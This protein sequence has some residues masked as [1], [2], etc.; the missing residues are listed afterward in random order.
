MLEEAIGRVR[1][2]FGEE[3]LY[4]STSATLLEQIVAS[5]VLPPHRIWAEPTRRNTLGAQ[6][7]IAA[8]LLAAGLKEVTLA[9]LTSDHVIG[10]PD[11][12]LECINAALEIA[13]ATGG[14]VTIGVSPTRP[15]TGFGYIEEKRGTQVSAAGGATAVRAKSFREKP[16]EETAENFIA[17][18]NFLWNSG[19]FFFTLEAF[20]GE[21]QKAQP[22]A[23]HITHAIADLLR[24]GDL[25]EA[26]VRFEELPNISIDYAVMEKAD[27][28]YVLRATFPWDDIGS[29]DAMDRTRARDPM[30]N[31]L[32]GRV[33][34]ADSRD[35]IVMDFHPALRVGVLGLQDMVVIVGE[36]AVLVC[37][38]RDA[39][40]VRLIAQ[41]DEAQ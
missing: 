16:S 15:E 23:F 36:E 31:V 40:R 21:L 12:L 37:H 3:R 38:K 9:I 8:S 17:A 5:G 35:C 32:D 28:V 18:G 7:W 4:I 25:A 27:N 1:N 24:T 14:I 6:C 26:T 11:R 29:W 33:L 34:V 20:L 10:E 13:E 39:Q 22:E 30:G 19:M 41:L 2:M